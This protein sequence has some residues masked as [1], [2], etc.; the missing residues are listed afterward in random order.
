MPNV[1]EFLGIDT[2]HRPDDKVVQLVKNLEE[3]PVSKINY[4]LAG[5]VKEDGVYCMLVVKGIKAAFFG[6]TGKM[7]QNMDHLIDLYFGKLK[8]KPGVY[9]GE[10]V[11]PNHSLEVLSG[12]VN[13][14]R[15]KP[16]DSIIEYYW[17]YFSAVQFHD[18]LSL[19]E[20]IVGRSDSNYLDRLHHISIAGF[21][22]ID[23]TLLPTADAVESFAKDCIEEGEEGAVFKDLNAPWVAGKKDYRAMKIVRRINYDLLCLYAEEGKGKYKGKVGNLIFQWRNGEKIKAM[24]GKDYSHEDARVMWKAFINKDTE[25]NPAGKIFRVYGLQDSSKGKIRLPKVG[26]VRHDKVSAD[27]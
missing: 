8:P 3:V 7:L 22:C 21:P 9:I 25:F 18:Y 17:R 27:F 24:L 14:N 4:P 16:L 5:Q 11:F 15:T 6:R 12:I 1:F 19:E 10:V 26:E 2:K 20:F 23:F 13:P